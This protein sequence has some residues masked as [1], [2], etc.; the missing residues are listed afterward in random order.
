MQVRKQ[1]FSLRQSLSFLSLESE[2]YQTYF[3]LVTGVFLLAVFGIYLWLV[4]VFGPEFMKNREPYNVTL[5]IRLYNAFQVF[6]CSAF[7]IRAHQLGLSFKYLWQCERFLWLSDLNRLELRIGFWM[8]LLLRIVEFVE[9]IFF[10]VRK[11]Q[12]Q[13]SF[14][15]IFHHIGS[16]LMAW[17]FIVSGA[18]NYW[19][20]DDLAL[21]QLIT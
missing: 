4:L 8:F 21:S 15:H 14:L 5:L 11:K 12:K 3:H 13:A 20:F 2:L 1:I 16:V 7:V 9:T 10:V 19:S 18:G 17:L 6:A